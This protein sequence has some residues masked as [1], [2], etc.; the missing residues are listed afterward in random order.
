[1]DN[2][3]VNRAFKTSAR[4]IFDDTNIEEVVDQ[5]FFI[6]LNK[7]DTYQGKGSGFSLQSIDGTLLGVYEFVPMSG[8]SYIPTRSDI[9]NKKAIIYHQNNDEQCFK[10]ALLAKHN[11]AQ[12]KYRISEDYS[13]YEDLYNISNINFPTPLHEVK[14]FEKNKVD[15]SINVYGLHQ[16]RRDRK[17]THSVYLLKVGKRRPL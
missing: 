14:L 2:S 9:A 8:S 12:N 6:I 15:V 3:W 5:M 7:E 4:A 1:M 17:V 13:Q 10:W 16:K 11:T